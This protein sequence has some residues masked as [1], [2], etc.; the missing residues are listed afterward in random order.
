MGILH[1]KESGSL[2][3]MTGGFWQWLQGD[4][5]S[6]RGDLG[7]GLCFYDL[8]TRAHTCD[9]RQDSTSIYSL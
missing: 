3:V 6:F 5:V 1:R 4:S 8:G 9:L 2:L 7:S